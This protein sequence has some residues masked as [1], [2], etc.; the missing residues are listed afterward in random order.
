MKK[1]WIYVAM[2]VAL[3]NGCQ[4]QQAV[5]DEAE[6][7]TVESSVNGKGSSNALNQEESQGT[8][9]DELSDPMDETKDQE[10]RE[11]S[12]TSG[13][14]S[15]EETWDD[16]LP[17]GSGGKPASVVLSQNCVKE[18]PFDGSTVSIVRSGKEEASQITEA[19][20]EAMVR[21]A[22]GDFD[23]VVKNGQTVV[24]KPNL[25]QMIVDS[26]GEKL[27]RQVNGVTT[28]WRVTKAVL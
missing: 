16:S 13:Y 7:L 25:V 23:T 6:S 11:E 28:D 2:P 12:G 14:E 15:A 3:L 4:R 1:F 22:A 21:E 24:I 10:D 26:T 18:A 9:G 8:G 20:I 27:D 5:L 19:E 17:Q